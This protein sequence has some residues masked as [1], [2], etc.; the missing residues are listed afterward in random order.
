VP[1]VAEGNGSSSVTVDPDIEKVILTTL[2]VSV[3]RRN[4]QVFE[5]A[6]ALKAIARLADAPVDTLAPHVRQWHHQGV[7]RSVIGEVEKGDPGRRRAS[8]YR[9]LV[10]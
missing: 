5:L 6:R 2:S 1:S 9:Y 8:R 4:R 7:A 3:G 10:E